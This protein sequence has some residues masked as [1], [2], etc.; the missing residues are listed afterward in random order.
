MRSLHLSTKTDLRGGVETYLDDLLALGPAH[1]H[2]PEVGWLEQSLRPGRWNLF[3]GEG[4]ERRNMTATE[5]GAQV[6]THAASRS[7]VVHLHTVDPA[8]GLMISRGSQATVLTYHDNRFHCLSGSKFFRFQDQACEVKVGL[9]CVFNAF[10]C[11]CTNRNPS[12]L[13][14]DF[15]RVQAER[16]LM[17][18]ASALIANSSYTHAALLECG[19]QADQVHTLNYFTRGV[20]PSDDRPTGPVLALGR[21]TPTKGFHHLV[22][23]ASFFLPQSPHS[24]VVIAGPGPPYAQLTKA[25]EILPDDIRARIHLVGAANGEEVDRLIRASSLVVVPSLYPEAFGIVGIEAMIRARAVIAY[26]GGG[27]SDWLQDGVTGRL[28]KS[29]DIASLSEAVSR[30]LNDELE[31]QM[32]G[33]AA[34][35]EATRLFNPFIHFAD[36]HRIY[37]RAALVRR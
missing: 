29:G 23:A 32:Y 8:L 24:S 22:R 4:L 2:D 7:A 12:N 25:I 14:N 35:S 33:Q 16:K 20:L 15:Q 18:A 13:I 37:R 21:M 3:I 34:Y 10:R 1:G 9:R 17:R 27:I 36:L 19:A 26:D 5:L 11:G 28:V 31:R 30:L 6:Q